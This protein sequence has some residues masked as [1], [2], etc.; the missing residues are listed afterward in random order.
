MLW[1][2][3]PCVIKSTKRSSSICLHSAI[4]GASRQKT[5]NAA[6][7]F[8]YRRKV[9]H[10][11]AI[12]VPVVVYINDQRRDATTTSVR[13]SGHGLI[14]LFPRRPFGYSRLRRR[15]ERSFFLVAA[16]PLWLH[17]PVPVYAA[18]KTGQS[19]QTQ[20]LPPHGSRRLGG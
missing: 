10:L 2:G 18:R 19:T 7:V 4:D 1:P 9:T 5:V 16:P 12:T 11:P 6:K 14:L 13:R 15:V 17:C 8:I 3:N 20:L